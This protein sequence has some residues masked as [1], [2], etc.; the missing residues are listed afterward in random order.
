MLSVLFLAFP[1]LA[2]EP[3]PDPVVARVEGIEIHASEFEAAAKFA[4]PADGIALT[5]DERKQVVEQIAGER[6]LYLEAKKDDAVLKDTLVRDTLV[7]VLLKNEIYADVH[8]PTNEELQAYYNANLNRFMTPD[9]ARV[10]RILV[11]TGPNVDARTAIVTA[12]KLRVA[13]AKD[14]KTT[15][16]ATAKKSSQDPNRMAG[17]DM[18]VV[19]RLDTKVDMTLRKMI[20][21]T[22]Q[23]TVSKVF[24][25][26]EGANIVYVSLR[27]LPAQMPFQQA[28]ADVVKRWTAEKNAEAKAAH[29]AKLRKGANVSIEKG[30]LAAVV[31]PV[32]KA[33]PV[34]K[35]AAAPAAAVAPAAPAGKVVDPKKTA[36]KPAK[37]VEVPPEAVQDPDE[38]E[39]IPDED[40]GSTGG[41]DG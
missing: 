2:A 11:R 21:A 8:E 12:T 32:R 15:F 10:S 38:I 5:D 16:A 22:R 26:K 41:Y 30:A 19:A 39:D 34:A 40:E 20:F 29:V 24:L 35:V 13:V 28:R 33:P 31:L 18:G 36:A 4:R 17:G 14:P 37:A 23:G 27:R 25:T 7:R 1:L 3:A 9:V 6:L